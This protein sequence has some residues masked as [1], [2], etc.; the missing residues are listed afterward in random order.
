MGIFNTHWPQ[1]F[2]RICGTVVCMLGWGGGGGDAQT[3]VLIH[4]LS[5]IQDLLG[6]TTAQLYMKAY[7]VSGSHRGKICIWKEIM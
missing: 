2:C 5:A 4:N 3:T 7:P 1:L 6:H